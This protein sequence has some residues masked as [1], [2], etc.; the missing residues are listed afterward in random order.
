MVR[1]RFGFT[2]VELLVVIAIMAVL[3]A[4]LLPA[5]QRAREAARQTQ[6][7]N[8]LKQIG[9]ALHNYHDRATMFPPGWIDSYQRSASS[10]PYN[11]WGWTSLILPQLEQLAISESCDF[12]QGHDGTTV[13]GPSYSAVN[14]VIPGLLCPSDI[15]SSVVTA[16]TSGKRLGAR[17]SYPGISGAT[18]LQDGLPG[19]PSLNIQNSLGGCF[20]AN[21]SSNTSAMT[22]GTANCIIV[23]ERAGVEVGGTGGYSVASLW[24]GPQSNDST[25]PGDYTAPT[26][27]TANGVALAVAVCDA[28]NDPNLVINAAI[29]KAG[30]VSLTNSLGGAGPQT[31]LHGISSYH[32]G[33][34]QFLL[35]DGSVRFLSESIDAALF[36]NLSQISDGADVGNF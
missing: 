28:V 1:R 32:S 22:D 34:A 2:V 23:G 25:T 19:Q 12:N 9:L 10:L 3:M 15:A 5:V 6:C 27:E 35:G 30:Q 20:A 29:K 18:A 33:G 11:S 7:A 4:L 26:R 13:T 31:I 24:A 21:S 17:S 36:S 14:T 8:N 16:G